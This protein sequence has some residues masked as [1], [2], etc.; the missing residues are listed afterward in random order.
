AIGI[1]VKDPTG[2]TFSKAGESGQLYMKPIL[3]PSE[4]SSLR[5]GKVRSIDPNCSTCLY[6]KRSC[7]FKGTAY[8]IPLMDQ[9]E[10]IGLLV[11]E[12][13]NGNMPDEEILQSTA[14]HLKNALK[15]MI[16][17]QK[18]TDQSTRDELTGL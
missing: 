6:S 10:T 12:S 16:L 9:E 2:S 14:D 7:R 3:S 5:D 13:R 4:C 15:N 1:F 18:L 11:V 8:T 17:Q